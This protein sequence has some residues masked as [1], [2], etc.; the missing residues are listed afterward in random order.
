MTQ[1][2]PSRI[3]TQKTVYLAREYL[4]IHVYCCIVPISKE[5]EQA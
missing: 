1:L 4:H 3:Y 2:F 5:M